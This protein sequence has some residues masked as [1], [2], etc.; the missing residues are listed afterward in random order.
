MDGTT[1]ILLCSAAGAAL[2][3]WALTHFISKARYTG[4]LSEKDALL[5]GRE[6]ALEAEK[7]LRAQQELNAA[8]RLAEARRDYDRSVEDLKQ[9]QA[10]TLAAVRSELALENEK[11]LKEREESL[12]REAELT[13]KN[14]TGG[15]DRNIREMKEA[16]E[17]QKKS[18]SED[19]SSIKTKLEE[20]V[21]HLRE[22]TEAIGNK[23]DNLA[24]ALRG[25]NKMQGNWGER[26]LSNI[27][28]QEGLVCGR[29]YDKE[30]YLRDDAGGIVINEDSGKRMRPDYI[31]HFPD[32]TDII[33]DAK[34]NL[35]AY[36]DWT[37]AK[38]GEARD[39]AARRN[40]AAVRAQIKGLSGKR[41]S[42]YV[43]SGRKTLGY[44]IM[45]VSN[46]GALQLART[47]DPGIV[48]DAFKSNVLI[49][50][51][52]TIMPFLRMIHTAWV[53][54]DQIRNQE[55]IV[56]AAQMMV[57]RVADF[58]E[59]NAAVGKKLQ[60]ALNAHENGTRKLQEGGQSIIHAANDVIKLGVPINPKKRQSLPETETPVLTGDTEQTMQ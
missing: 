29:D 18:H 32:E 35:D 13:M 43:R 53:N 50:T 60:E 37:E 54:V 15:L 16:F 36:V 28:E 42:D 20:A 48:N 17:A 12:R 8:D 21:S 45:F 57:E 41:Y 40:L 58:C 10:Q 19:S 2:V 22:Q 31:L 5:A 11:A 23:A 7:A 44:V 59:A 1:I 52:E 6:A 55:K 39:E 49:T 51:E 30:E 14:I 33:I 56:K 24:G 46:Y 27:F 9:S 4:K 25:G 34:M 38:T 3:T 26:K 47:L